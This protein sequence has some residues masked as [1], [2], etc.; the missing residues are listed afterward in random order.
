[1][2]R[3]KKILLSAMSAA[4]VAGM[5][6]SPALADGY[7]SQNQLYA[8]STLNGICSEAQRIVT[9]SDL[10][11]TNA[12]YSP[13][14]GFV[15]SD[16][17]PYSVVG[18]STPLT[19][20]PPEDPD[21]PL[22][23]TQHLFY[24]SYRLGG[25]EYPTVVS[26]KMK[27]AEYLNARDPDLGAVDQPCKAVHDYYVGEVLASLPSWRRRR[28]EAN[29]V[30]DEDINFQRGSEWTARFPKDPFP[31]I[32]REFEGGPIHIIAS[33]LYVSPHPD[34]IQ[35][36]PTLNFIEVCNVTGGPDGFLG[37]ACEP[38]KWGV[39]YCHLASPEYIRAALTRRVDLPT[40]GT[41]TADNRVCQ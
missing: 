9:A 2:P 18:G 15:Q 6:V 8:T 22:G 31:V 35:F 23:S 30:L 33:A 21:R 40:C 7:L 4:V 5:N 1:M 28:A 14:E 3:T 16:A 19:Y 24:E 13:W 37:S 11:A 17:V 36:S 10:D 38:R 39:R 32:Y 20:S 41:P 25:S 29:L 27:N 26:C 34:D 12:V